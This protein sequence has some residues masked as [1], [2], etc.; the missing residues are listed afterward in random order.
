MVKAENAS[1][2]EIEESNK[3]ASEFEQILN[4][5]KKIDSIAR[6]EHNRWNA[7][8]RSDGWQSATLE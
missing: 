7:F 1:P 5:S 6:I 3:L 8:I 2:E 4:D